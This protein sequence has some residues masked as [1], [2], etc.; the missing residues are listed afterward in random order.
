[1]ERPKIT[2]IGSINMDLVTETE[3]VPQIGETVLGRHFTTF[4]GGKGANQAVA[5]AR[6]NADVT[7]I[8]CVGDDSFGAELLS[9]LQQENIFMQHVEPVT[10]ISTGIASITVQDGDNS[11]IVVPGANYMLTPEKV[12]EL[13]AV[14]RESDILL[15]Q[16]EIPFST[17]RQAVEVAYRNQVPVILNPA[18]AAELP[19]DLL[20]KISIL[21]PNEYELER[22]LGLKEGEFGG[23]LSIL[24]KFPGR[25]VLTKG[26]EGAYYTLSD[27]TLRHEKARQVRVV[28]TTGAGDTF[29]AALAVKISQ[30]ECLEEAV[31]YAV[32]A[33]ALSV[34][35]FGA[36]SGMPSHIDV[37]NFIKQMES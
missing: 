28:D 21:T 8:G 34:T 3:K 9:H 33:S 26:S 35:M 27:G 14:I 13:E 17:V 16:L 19:E 4:P 24:K 37:E 2:V 31:K 30:G 20:R 36:Q 5:C 1:M 25:M 18:P 12:M 7:L 11:I 22:L 10:H 32:A 29:N 23:N 15:L 6:L